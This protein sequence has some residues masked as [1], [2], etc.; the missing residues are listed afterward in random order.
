[1]YMY[2]KFTTSQIYKKPLK[3]MYMYKSSQALKSISPI[4]YDFTFHVHILRFH[5]DFFHFLFYAEYEV[6]SRLPILL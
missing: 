4:T 2:K 3:N 1:M 6:I 5:W